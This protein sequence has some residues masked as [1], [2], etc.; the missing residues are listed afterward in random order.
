MQTV[1]VNLP[2]V[3]TAHAFVVRLSSLDGQFDLLS[4]GYVIDAKS[5]M[6]IFSLDRTKPLKLRVEKDT[7]S[8]MLALKD[9]IA[10]KSPERNISRTALEV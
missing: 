5:L 7:A 6:G 2:T 4:E 8:T 9:F 10:E 3:E 1:L